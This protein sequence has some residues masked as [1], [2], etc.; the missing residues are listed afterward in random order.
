M[1]DLYDLLLAMLGVA[2]AAV[3]LVAGELFLVTRRGPAET[4]LPSAVVTSSIE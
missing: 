4:H 3:L 2:I 1:D